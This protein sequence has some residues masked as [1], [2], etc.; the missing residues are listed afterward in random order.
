RNEPWFRNV[1]AGS[2]SQFD[3]TSSQ[4]APQSGFESTSVPV[5]LTEP[6]VGDPE[7]MGEFVDDGMSND[8][9]QPVGAAA[10]FAF[11]IRAKQRDAIGQHAGVPH[12]SLR[13][14]DALVQSEQAGL[15]AGRGVVD[16][17]VDVLHGLL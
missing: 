12:A 6:V 11:D 5:D 1:T 17:D 10:R 15:T 8:L 13:Q 4:S 2:R 16:E 7:V 9:S 3:L 14:G